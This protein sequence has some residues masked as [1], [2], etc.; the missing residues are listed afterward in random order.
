MIVGLTIAGGATLGL[1]R[2]GAHTGIGAIWW[3]FALVG[4]G[5]GGC[6]TPMT[7]IAVAAVGPERAGMASAVHNAM[8]QL[9][10]V[11]GV[12]VLGAL[13]YAGQPTGAGGRRLTG[14]AATHFVTVAARCAGSPPNVPLGAANQLPI[15]YAVRSRPVPPGAPGSIV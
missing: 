3:D 1:L 12:A 8:R 5:F 2:L 14:S 6:L 13:V 7:T 9:G 11:L 4:I 10:Q 15:H